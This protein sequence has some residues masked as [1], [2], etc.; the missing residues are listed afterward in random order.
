MHRNL[1]LAAVSGRVA[2][3]GDAVRVLYEGMFEDGTV[4]DSSGETPLAFTLGK[5]QVVRGFEAAV[6]GLRP[7]D[8][9]T[10][11]LPPEEAYGLRD[12][13]MVITVPATAAPEGLEVGM[14]VAIGPNRIA[15]R[16]LEISQEGT[17]TIDAN[18]QL[19]GMTLKFH[20]E[21]LGFR[22]LLAAAPAAGLELATF[23]A[24]CFW[25]VELAFQRVPGVLQTNVGYAQGQ[26]E[27]PTYKDICSGS[28]G[29]TECVR[30]VYDPHQVTFK[31]LLKT[32]WERV[33]KNATT[34]NLA[35]NDEGT[36]YRSGIYTHTE[37][38]RQEAEASCRELEA[39][40]GQ[41]V[42]TEVEA[43]APFW[44]AEDYHQQYL[45]KGGRNARPQNAAKGC[46]ET[47]RCY[48]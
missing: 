40:L 41:K 7:G 9:V 21:L 32:F 43:A 38:Q 24:G 28:T 29:H 45:E 22:E 6:R 10:V 1:A 36:Q 17:V 46:A 13:S 2:V 39:R 20:I 44:L 12:E 15:A 5:G 16:V 26:Q 4:F 14:D 42:V 37:V 34:L 18:P 47:L 25:G 35:G 31:E 27:E 48:G 3:D 11:V 33:G 19:A 23:A 30:V 8:K